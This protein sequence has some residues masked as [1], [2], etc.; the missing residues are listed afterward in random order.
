MKK[1]L[2]FFVVAYTTLFGYQYDTVIIDIEAKLFPKIALMEKSVQ[3]S[4]SKRLNIWI[5]YKKID[6]KMA[7]KFK[8][9]IEMLYKMPLLG[10]KITVDTVLMS[11]YNKMQNLP[12]AL[13]VLSYDSKEMKDIAKWANEN[14]IVSF[15]YEPK[16]LQYGFLGS[17]YI[18]LCV[19]PYLNKKTIKEFGFV[20]T[21]YLLQL[22]KF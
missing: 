22:S 10:K 17:V 13:I 5:V 11:Q 14:K 4:P 12:D 6:T 2:L 1:L 3:K 18:G 15:V 8:F 21:P 9:K 19:K 16:D 7:K 20:L